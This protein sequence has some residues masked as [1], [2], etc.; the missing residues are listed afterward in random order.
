MNDGTDELV[1]SAALQKADNAVSGASHRPMG[2]PA[3]WL[4]QRAARV[5][6]LT[7]AR[8]RA[9]GL[10]PGDRKTPP[11]RSEKLENLGF[12]LNTGLRRPLRPGGHGIRVPA[13]CRPSRG[14]S[15][16]CE[17][18]PQPDPTQSPAPARLA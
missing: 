2:F 9:V 14:S 7:H 15:A 10:Q 6:R 17:T 11:V 4:T 13:G 12:I 16:L 3:A 8:P 18:E 5:V 1:K